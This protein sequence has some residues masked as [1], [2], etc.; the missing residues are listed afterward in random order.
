[1]FKDCNGKGQVPGACWACIP[2]SPSKG[3]VS[4][5]DNQLECYCL[6]W[7]EYQTPRMWVKGS[8]ILGVEKRWMKCYVKCATFKI[9]MEIFS[10]TMHCHRDAKTTKYSLQTERNNFWMLKWHFILKLRTIKQTK[11]LLSKKKVTQWFILPN[12]KFKTEPMTEACKK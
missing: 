11:R 1:M 4:W 8:Q 7:S 12:G 3:H 9:R 6:L 5:Q 10:Q 2:C